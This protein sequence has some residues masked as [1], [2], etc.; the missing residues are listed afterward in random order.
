VNALANEEVGKY[1]NVHFISAYQKIGTFQIQGNQKQGG[2]VASY[3]CTPSGRVLHVIAG[4]VDAP[5]LLREAQWVRETDKLARL[6]A[7]GEAA[8]Y[9]QVFREAHAA[10]LRQEHGLDLDV[11]NLPTGAGSAAALQPLLAKI[12]GRVS[13][14]QGRVHLLMSVAPVPRIEEVYKAVF[15]QILGE[16]VSTNPVAKND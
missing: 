3:F 11:K 16:K 15:E 13:T 2:N 9:R 7:H 14:N 1:L 12:K 8:R 4:P 10:R 6:E 5:T